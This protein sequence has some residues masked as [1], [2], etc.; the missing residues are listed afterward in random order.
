MKISKKILSIFLS[1]LI[2]FLPVAVHAQEVEEL[3]GRIVSIEKDGKAPFSGILLDTT[4]ASKITI[5]KKYSLL[6]YELE[7]DLSLK[8]LAADYIL[9]VNTLQLK[10]DT[11]KLKTDSI[12]KIKSDE[13]LRLQDMVKENPNDYT[14]W[15]M[16]GGIAVGVLLSI[17]IFFAA[18]EV[19]K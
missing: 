17:G 5:D 18:V 19:A 16:A 7:L 11:L 14:H 1:S 4:A 10:H 15:W 3:E 2:I 8:K 9:Q 6:K 12:L 13:I